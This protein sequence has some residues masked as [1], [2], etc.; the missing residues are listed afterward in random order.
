MATVRRVAAQWQEH[1]EVPHTKMV[2]LLLHLTLA[3]FFFF[4]L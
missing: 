1:R 3:V 4:S 2:Q